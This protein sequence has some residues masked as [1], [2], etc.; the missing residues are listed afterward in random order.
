MLSV[1]ENLET[2]Q[3]SSLSVPTLSVIIVSYGYGH[4]VGQAIDS[5]LGQTSTP[6]KILVVDDYAKD[7]ACDVAGKYEIDFIEREKNLGVVDNFNDI[8]FNQVK[9]DRVMFLGADNWLRP[10]ALEKMR[11]DTDIVSSDMYICGSDAKEARA[12]KKSEYIDGYWIKRFKDQGKINRSNFIHGSSIYNVNLAKE[13]GGYEA[14]AGRE[15]YNRKEEDWMLWKKMI[16]AGATHFHVKD[17][18]LYYRR[19]KFN[20]C[21][22]Y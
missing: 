2:E 22:K 7:G 20:F 15:N 16:K 4:L 9:T 13:V 8:L 21:G 11:L 14:R 1:Q 6:D 17:P 19:H 5:V 10:D 18:L 12:S 3:T